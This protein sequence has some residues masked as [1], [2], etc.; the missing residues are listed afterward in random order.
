VEEYNDF[1]DKKKTPSWP[2][3]TKH[4][5]R[6]NSH[7]QNKCAKQHW[8]LDFVPAGFTPDLVLP[9]CAAL[10]LCWFS[11]FKPSSSQKKTGRKKA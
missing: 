5:S 1:L 11:Y 7:C 8:Q 2:H 3:D 9:S 10:T 6:M 4:W